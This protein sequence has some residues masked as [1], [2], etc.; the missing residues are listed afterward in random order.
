VKNRYYTPHTLPGAIRTKSSRKLAGSKINK[1]KHGLPHKYT[2]PWD[3]S[4]CGCKNDMLT[5]ACPLLHEIY[6]WSRLNGDYTKIKLNQAYGCYDE[7]EYRPAYYVAEP[8]F[9]SY[10]FEVYN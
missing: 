4:R 3:K 9:R 6:K 7:Y 8:T 10:D 5:E 2:E 1:P